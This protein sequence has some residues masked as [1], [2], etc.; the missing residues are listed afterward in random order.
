M[1]QIITQLASY[2]IW[3]NKL[4]LGVINS[5]SQEQQNAELA[6]S[7]RSLYKTVLHMWRAEAIWWNRLNLQDKTEVPAET[8]QV[9]F[10]ILSQHLLQQNKKWEFWLKDVAEETLNQ[11]FAY[12]NSKG[13]QFE[14]SVHEILIHVFNHSTYHR[15]Q[16]VTM[17]RGLYVEK[18]PPTDFILFTRK[19]I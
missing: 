19:K 6:S 7:F 17:L 16:L 18:I 15:G 13:E 2:T 8:L 5:L 9:D 14:Q 1:K 4:V 12:C 11:E 3:A 10:A